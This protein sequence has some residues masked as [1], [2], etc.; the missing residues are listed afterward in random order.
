MKLEAA[1][2]L[3]ATTKLECGC[4]AASCVHAKL[5]K[6]QKQLDV[7]G[8]GEISSDDLRRLRK[9]EKPKN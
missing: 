7:N 8:D 4:L 9:G 1:S 3:K 6:K 2:R 5:T